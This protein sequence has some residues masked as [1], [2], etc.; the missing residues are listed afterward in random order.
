MKFIDTHCHI[1]PGVDDGPPD[2]AASLVMARMAAVDGIN[3]IVATPHVIEGLYDGRERDKRLAQL[4]EALAAE[5][6]AINLYAGAE[7]PMSMCL[8]RTADFL[9]KMTLAGSR[10][11][12]ME[13]AD[14]TYDQLSRAVH[15]VRLNGLYPIL[16]H[17]ERV[18][19]VRERPSSLA[20][21]TAQGSVY[22]QLT[23]AS[24]EGLFGKSTYRC[25]A[26]LLKLGLAHLVASDGHSADK[27]PPLLSD[28]HHLIREMLGREAARVIMLDNPRKVLQDQP[29]ET[30]AAKQKQRGG[31]IS[32]MIRGSRA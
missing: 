2:L 15:Q 3:A 5:G 6:I 12:L 30:I 24:I 28:C 27:R 23:A 1:L 14:T 31:F 32:R 19:F 26:A 8:A 13:T 20:G 4:S 9:G 10:Y 7:V 16:A 25:A 21:I 18:G 11:L 29:L 22:C 17:P